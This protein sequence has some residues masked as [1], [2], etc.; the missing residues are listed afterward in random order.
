MQGRSLV[1]L[2]I[3]QSTVTQ[4]QAGPG[5]TESAESLT[6]PGPCHGAQGP[7]AGTDSDQ[8]VTGT[9]SAGCRRWR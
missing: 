3:V 1:Q 8:I 4:W 2:E 5:V 9:D 6:W 7:Q